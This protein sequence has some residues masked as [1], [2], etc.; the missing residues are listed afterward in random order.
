MTAL[1]DQL[2]A[3]GKYPSAAVADLA[4]TAGQV[5]RDANGQIR[6]AG[7]TTAVVANVSAESQ[8]AALTLNPGGIAVPAKGQGNNKW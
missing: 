2:A 5:R 7:S 6:C 1:A 8:V 3:Q 4:I